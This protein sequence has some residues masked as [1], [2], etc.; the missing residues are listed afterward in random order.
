MPIQIYRALSSRG[1]V[2]STTTYRAV[3]ATA[4]PLLY[5]FVT[6]SHVCEQLDQG[7]YLEADR[8]RFE[9]ATFWIASKHSTVIHHRDLF[10]RADHFSD[11][12]KASDMVRSFSEQ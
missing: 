3:L 8:R 11:D 4:R 10:T 5:C 9:P 12:S 2:I 6:E 7:C 1:G